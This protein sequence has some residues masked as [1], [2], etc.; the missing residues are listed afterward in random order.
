LA[1]K[2]A[3][4]ANHVGNSRTSTRLVELESNRES[5]LRFRVRLI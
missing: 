3:Y 2:L 1:A 5:S 4:F